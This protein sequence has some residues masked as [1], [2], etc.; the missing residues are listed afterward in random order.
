VGSTIQS[1][2]NASP[3]GVAARI[4]LPYEQGRFRLSVARDD[5]AVD[6]A[7]QLRFEVFNL[8]LGEGLASSWATGRDVDALDAQF[9]HLIVEDRESRRV[10]GTYRLQTGEMAEAGRGFYSADEFDLSTLP[11]EVLADAVELGRACIDRGY[12]NRQVLFLLWKGLASYL[13]VN[14]KRYLFGCSS[15]TSQDPSQGLA[16][17]AELRRRGY[18]HPTLHVRPRAGSICEAPAGKHAASAE[19][20][21]PTLF[22]TYLRFGGTICGPPAIDRAFRTIDFLTWLDTGTLDPGVRRMF[23]DET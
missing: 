23:F 9:H 8:E 3:R 15:L 13:A 2:S 11:P 4:P 12:R 5:R 19:V 17:F 21:I 6:A 10:I 14:G 22:E 20:K 7:L 18:L 16:A 1:A